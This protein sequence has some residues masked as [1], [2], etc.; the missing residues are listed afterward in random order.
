MYKLKT[1]AELDRDQLKNWRLDNIIWSPIA[2][3]WSPGVSHS[4]QIEHCNLFGS[5][6][7]VFGNFIQFRKLLMS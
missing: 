7:L 6:T 1:M 5:I 4:S 3:F 2:E